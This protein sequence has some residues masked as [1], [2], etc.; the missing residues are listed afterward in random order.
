MKKSA[1]IIIPIAA[2]AVVQMILLVRK[3]Q[4]TRQ[5]TKYILYEVA[6][7][8]YETAEDVLFPLKSSRLSRRY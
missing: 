5:R 2:L 6:E 1:K 4:R 7:A 3:R 8:G